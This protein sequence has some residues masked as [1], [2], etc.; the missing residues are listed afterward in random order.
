MIPWLEICLFQGTDEFYLKNKSYVSKYLRISL[1]KFSFAT[2][3]HY[4]SPKA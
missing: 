3:C 4:L 1:A 2:Q